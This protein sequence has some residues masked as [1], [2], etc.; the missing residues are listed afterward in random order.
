M[1][2]EDFQV[3]PQKTPIIIPGTM[4]AQKLHEFVEVHV[5]YATTG[6][7][8]TIEPLRAR[9]LKME[10]GKWKMEVRIDQNAF[11]Y[12]ILSGARIVKRTAVKICS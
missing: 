11:K 5:K 2:D 10:R 7:R 12:S 3:V 8:G 1:E 4:S 9:T 6:G